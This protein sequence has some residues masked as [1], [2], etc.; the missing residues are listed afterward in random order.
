LD[1]RRNEN[2]DRFDVTRCGRYRR[3]NRLTSEVIM[4]K[5]SHSIV[6]MALALVF[7][8]SSTEARVV[9]FIRFRRRP[10]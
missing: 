3:A 8:A 6:S 7:L 9:R 5:P 4:L 2:Q 1:G 10:D